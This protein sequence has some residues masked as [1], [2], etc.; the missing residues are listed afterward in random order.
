MSVA[1]SGQMR[2]EGPGAMH[3]TPEVDVHQPVEVFICNLKH[4]RIDSH[5][6]VIDQ[7]ID[8]AKV[9]HHIIG[10]GVDGI[11]L[12]TIELVVPGLGTQ[13]SALLSRGSD[14]IKVDI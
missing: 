1:G 12:A 14:V 6:G 7:E 9:T 2:E 3:H 11:S 13:C 4:L 5:A 10:I 8:R